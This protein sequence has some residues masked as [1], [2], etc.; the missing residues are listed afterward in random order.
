M[1][2]EAGIEAH[3]APS[4]PQW[5]EA[6]STEHRREYEI[7]KA[8]DIQENTERFVVI[9]REHLGEDLNPDA[10]IAL[11]KR[12]AENMRVSHDGGVQVGMDEQKPIIERLGR[13]AGR[14][15]YAIA[16]ME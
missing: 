7:V 6:L 12:M 9:I 16:N 3:R 4:N 2:V 1:T 11:A 14:L 5:V 13:E 15:G 8:E 10:V